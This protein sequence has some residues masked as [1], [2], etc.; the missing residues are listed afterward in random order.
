MVHDPGDE[1]ITAAEANALSKLNS[2]NSLARFNAEIATAI[3]VAIAAGLT[4]ATVKSPACFDWSGGKFDGIEAVQYGYHVF[5]LTGKSLLI[6][7]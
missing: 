1:M 6:E 3:E 2:A 5:E 7:W 4:S